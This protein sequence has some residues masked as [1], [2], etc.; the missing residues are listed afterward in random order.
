MCGFH[1]RSLP[2]VWRTMIKPGVKFMDLFCLKNI[3]ETTL[4]TAWKRQS[5]RE[6]SSRKKSRSLLSMVKTQCRWMQ[7]TSLERHVVPAAGALE[8]VIAERK[9]GHL[10]PSAEAAEDGMS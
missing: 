3:R 2:K 6:R 7:L 1:F 9:D 5:S 10:T 4:F 8:R